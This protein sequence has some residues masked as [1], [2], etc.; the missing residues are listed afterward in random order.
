MVWRSGEPVSDSN[1]RQVQSVFTTEPFRV[2][3]AISIDNPLPVKDWSSTGQAG[4]GWKSGEPVA[5]DNLL[6]CACPQGGATFTATMTAEDFPSYYPQHDGA[7]WTDKNPMPVKIVID[8]THGDMSQ[9]FE[10]GE[11]ISDENPLPIQVEP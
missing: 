9:A 3:E 4:Q 11:A 1:P 2:G 7:P 5:D 10:S 8:L 6:P